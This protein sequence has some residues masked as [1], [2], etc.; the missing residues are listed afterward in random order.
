LK[1][2]DI[3]T[4][5]LL[6]AI[7]G[8]SFL[9]MRLGIGAFGAVPIAFLR[10]AGAAIVL[11]P[12]LHA[13]GQWPDLARHWKPIALVGITNAAL[14]FIFFASASRTLSVGVL[15]IF[16]AS[17]ALFAAL[18]AWWWLGERLGR[19]RVLGLVIGFLGVF[20]LAAAKS[21]LVGSAATSGLVGA[22][23]T[24]G[25]VGSATNE[26][27]ADA[28]LA[29]GACLLATLSYGLS[30]SLTKRLLTGVAP[31]A[32]AAGSLL[33]GAVVLAVPAWLTW[34]DA[35]PDLRS[36]LATL[37]LSV[38]CTGWAYA[39]FFKLIARI[40]P[41][42]AIAVTFLVPA[43]AV[44]WG[45]LFLA[46]TITPAMLTGCAVIFAGTALATGVLPRRAAGHALERAPR[47]GHEAT[48]TPVGRRVADAADVIGPR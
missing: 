44:A 13:R 4:L 8:G 31:M 7:W 34:P 39:I 27:G 19:L 48:T 16:N 45:T 30:V 3:A 37:A 26:G 2:R 46:E 20:G 24:S 18:I 47:P 42:N 22:V 36:A 40:G 33:A 12:V 15:S 29:I 25:L 17:T 1:R 43:F 10:V 32:I 38:V 21:G 9:F 23:A 41:T 6:A 11:L 14:P 5:L 35:T 28:S